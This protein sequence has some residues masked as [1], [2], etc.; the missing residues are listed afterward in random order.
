MSE[1]TNTIN[2]VFL[3]V[4]MLIGMLFMW[5]GT[6]GDGILNVVYILFGLLL[7]VVA[8]LTHNITSTIKTI[9]V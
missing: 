7:F 8:G 9:K 6:I 3:V 2:N 4:V 1:Y 5:Q